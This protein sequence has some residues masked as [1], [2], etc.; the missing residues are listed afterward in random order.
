MDIRYA[1]ILMKIKKYNIA[2][3]KKKRRITFIVTE[4]YVKLNIYSHVRNFLLIKLSFNFEIVIFVLR[5]RYDSERIIQIKFYKYF[6]RKLSDISVLIW[7][8]YSNNRRNKIHPFRFGIPRVEYSQNYFD[9]LIN[10]I[11][12]PVRLKIINYRRRYNNIYI[13]K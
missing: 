10:T 3:I 2:N 5:I 8:Q 6:V 11:E 9:D 7:I 12:L 1:V 13:R 4:F